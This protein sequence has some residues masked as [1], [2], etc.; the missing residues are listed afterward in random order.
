MQQT[1]NA[2]AVLGPWSGRSRSALT[3][4][5]DSYTCVNVF[6][7]P[8]AS[9]TPHGASIEATVIFHK[10]SLLGHVGASGHVNRRSFSTPRSRYLSRSLAGTRAGPGA[11]S[12]TH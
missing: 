9:E 6:M 4:Q 12:G 1:C 7:Q 11:W 3:D 10:V 8:D 2:L 5:P